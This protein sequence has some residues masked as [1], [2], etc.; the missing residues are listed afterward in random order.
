VNRE[1]TY[2]MPFERLTKLSRSMS[3]KAFSTSWLVLW[4]LFAAYIAALVAIIVFD[5]TVMSWQ[6]ALGL[7][8]Y[9]AFVLIVLLFVIAVWSLRRQGLQVMKGR[10]NFDDAVRFR[11]DEGGLR[12]A[13]SQIEYYVKWQGISQMLMDRDGVAISHGALFFLIPDSAFVDLSERN[14]LVRDVFGRLGPAAQDRSEKH[15]RPALDASAG[16]A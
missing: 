1:L 2:Q 9:S 14:A 13:T 16:M 12:F 11:K 8:P 7:P 10:A 5:D 6:H 3:R 15:I 4:T